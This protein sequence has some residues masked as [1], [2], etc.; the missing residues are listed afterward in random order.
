MQKNFFISSIKKY[1][2]RFLIANVAFSIVIA[3]IIIYFFLQ[4]FYNLFLGPFE[5]SKEA[6]LSVPELQLDNSYKYYPTYPDIFNYMENNPLNYNY[7]ETDN[8]YFFKLNCDK[9]YNSGIDGD[10][11]ITN[12]FD[13]ISLA[14]DEQYVKADLVFLEINNKLLLAEVPIGSDIK[15]T[16]FGMLLPLLPELKDQILKSTSNLSE[17]D[18]YPFILVSTNKF[19]SE[20]YLGIVFCALLVLLNLFNYYRVILR[21][22]SIKNNPTYKR[23]GRY[24]NEEEVIESI[25]AEVEST[26]GDNGITKQFVTPSWIINSG[27]FKLKVTK[28]HLQKPKY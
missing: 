16:Y 3:F 19:K 26:F 18:L 15:D 27:W 28:N 7:Y 13:G 8:K 25:N 9:V 14:P 11:T 20:V 10:N 1:N 6:L 24:G 4:S 21:Y 22:K 2:G 17:N 5:L 12:K 23:I